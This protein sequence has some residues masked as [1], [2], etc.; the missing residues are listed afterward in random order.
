MEDRIFQLI[1]DNS[2]QMSC[3]KSDSK[4]YKEDHSRVINI[5]LDFTENYDDSYY[6]LSMLKLFEAHEFCNVLVFFN[7]KIKQ[8]IN[9]NDDDDYDEF[10]EMWLTTKR[11]WSKIYHENCVDIKHDTFACNDKMYPYIRKI[12]D[13]HMHVD[14]FIP[15]GHE[16]C[17]NIKEK[18]NGD[19]EYELCYRK[20]AEKE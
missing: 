1:Q 18:A 14:W 17:M 15:E 2:L 20:T 7:N 9:S 12:M 4:T 16:A 11:R 13:L 10:E 19:A 8:V 5:E 6:S 3:G